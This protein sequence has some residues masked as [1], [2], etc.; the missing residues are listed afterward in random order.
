MGTLRSYSVLWIG[1]SYLGRVVTQAKTHR[2]VLPS[3]SWTPPRL[4]QPPCRQKPSVRKMPFSVFS[5]ISLWHQDDYQQHWL[6]CLKPCENSKCICLCMKNLNSAFCSHRLCLAI[7]RK[8]APLTLVC[9]EPTPFTHTYLRYLYQQPQFFPGTGKKKKKKSKQTDK[10]KTMSFG[11]LFDSKSKLLS[12][13][14]P[15]TQCTRFPET[16]PRFP[17]LF[18]VP[19]A[20]TIISLLCLCFN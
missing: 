1:Y 3:P 19:P 6:G 12:L 16:V 13:K 14:L 10:Q 5:W 20:F 17:N 18:S 7:S 9:P 2:N 4:R 8:W 15:K 11:L